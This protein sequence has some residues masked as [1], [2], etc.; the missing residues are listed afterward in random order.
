MPVADRRERCIVLAFAH[1]DDESFVHRGHGEEVP[2]A[3]KFGMT[4][5]HRRDRA[6]GRIS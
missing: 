1:P 6:T 5:S 2:L 4:D 3:L